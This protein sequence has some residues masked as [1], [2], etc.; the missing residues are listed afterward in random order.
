MVIDDRK[1]NR[2]DY[3]IIKLMLNVNERQTEYYA[4]FFD[5]ENDKPLIFEN[6]LLLFDENA[7]IKLL[8]ETENLKRTNDLEKNIDLVYDSKKVFYLIMRRSIDM[9]AILVNSINIL[10]DLINSL[11]IEIP[12]NL[13][14]PIF[15]LADHLTFY[16]RY[17][18]FLNDNQISRESVDEFFQWIETVIVNNSV[19]TSYEELSKFSLWS[20]FSPHH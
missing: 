19:V 14:K 17:G 15:L 10:L 16:R 1:V 18:K 2:Q 3:W 7:V 4:L 13:K 12:P 5:K 6:K 20:V 9:E 8:N 11:L